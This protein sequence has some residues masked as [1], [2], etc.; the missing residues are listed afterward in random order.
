MNC[1]S[2]HVHPLLVEAMAAWLA[3][4]TKPASDQQRV[5]RNG[6]PQG[7]RKRKVTA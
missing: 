5:G 3:R 7:G 2:N 4:H 1:S 6:Q